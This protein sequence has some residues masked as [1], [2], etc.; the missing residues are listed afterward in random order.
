MQGE[1]S[2]EAALQ[3]FFGQMNSSR[4]I[5]ALIGLGCSLATEA[6]A[7]IS[8]YYSLILVRSSSH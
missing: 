6:I 4:Q 8:Q 7:E 3:E 2:R 5:L 1:C